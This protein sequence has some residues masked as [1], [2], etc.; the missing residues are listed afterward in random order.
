MS[1]VGLSP[2]DIIGAAQFLGKGVSALRHGARES[3]N[4]VSTS[5]QARTTAL[6]DLK[7]LA[8]ESG[9]NSPARTIE[10]I[11]P[12]LL[13][14]ERGINAKLDK[15][16]SPLGNHPSKH[17]KSVYHK[18]K[19]ALR[20]EDA[21]SIHNARVSPAFEAVLLQAIMFVPTSIDLI[22]ADGPRMVGTNVK[23][24]SSN[25]E[26]RLSAIANAQ[27]L[28]DPDQLRD[29]IQKLDLLHL[30]S[31]PASRV[32]P[33]PSFSA[34]PDADLTI[35]ANK[36]SGRKMR[37]VVAVAE[38]H[39]KSLLQ[40]LSHHAQE[41]LSSAA[42]LLRQSQVSSRYP[43]TLAGQRYA[44]LLNSL[45]TIACLLIT[46]HNTLPTQ[47]STLGG[48]TILGQNNHHSTVWLVVTNIFLASVVALN[49]P[50]QL[51]FLTDDSIRFEDAYGETYRIPLSFCEHP[52]IL[53]GYLEARYEAR[54]EV[55]R[56]RQGQYCILY[57]SEYGSI[58]ESVWLHKWRRYVRPKARL[59]M[60]MLFNNVD[61]RCVRCYKRLCLEADGLWRW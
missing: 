12:T 56:I 31:R 3:Y 58:V 16:R 32:G 2:G 41:G 5:H 37:R 43:E 47:K 17:K 30:G 36:T 24:L 14:Q 8:A 25:M 9:T 39:A 49:I 52:R 57:S 26:A 15:Y 42:C 18:L 28:L 40:S 45:L 23:T 34:T 10:N 38:S 51:S 11:V 19:W 44:L 60:A 21:V 4:E 7:N 48:L 61:C 22:E 20:E 54:P 55:W 46:L 27:A 59:L 35:L 50:M 29:L 33:I 53:Q 6:N 1:V 13:Q